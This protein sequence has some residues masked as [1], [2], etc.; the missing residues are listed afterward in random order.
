MRNHKKV[1][2]FGVGLL[3]LVLSWA[4][5]L[6][7][8]YSEA[9]AREQEAFF[10]G[11]LPVEIEASGLVRVGERVGFR[12]GCG[13]AIFKL[14]RSTEIGIEQK[15]LKYFDGALRSRDNGPRKRE[16]EPWNRTPLPRGSNSERGW[17][18]LDCLSA[19][20]PANDLL[21]DIVRRAAYLEGAY[22]TFAD[23]R[24]TMV[25]IPKLGVIVYAF[26][27]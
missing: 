19:V 13:A 5:Y 12:G 4:A 24:L 1:A 18:G 25:V 15:G 8:Q 3:I 22:F 10:F 6:S 14:S 27:D 11:R 26:Y 23:F 17:A 2:L 7:L 20:D 16:Y 9:N 21:V